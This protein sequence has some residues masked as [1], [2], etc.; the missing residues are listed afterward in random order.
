MTCSKME[1]AYLEVT[2]SLTKHRLLL[3]EQQTKEVYLRA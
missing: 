3:T 1:R 2:Y